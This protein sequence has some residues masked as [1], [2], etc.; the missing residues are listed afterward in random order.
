MATIKNTYT[1]SLNLTYDLLGGK[2]KMRILW[3]IIHDHNRFSLLL[4]HIP[5]ITE[6]VLMSQLREMEGTGL[7]IRVVLSEKP[8]HVEYR[9]SKAYDQ[10][11]PLIEQLCAF[12]NTYATDHGITIA[13]QKYQS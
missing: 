9:L 13:D 1:C 5:E 2:W 6:K 11:A 8:R 4:K 3:H 10:L 12:S 7:L